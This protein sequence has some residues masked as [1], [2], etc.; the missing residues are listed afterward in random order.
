MG[1]ITLDGGLALDVVG[2]ARFSACGAGSVADKADSAV[3]AEPLVTGMS[4]ISVAFMADPGDVG[5]HWVERN[6]GAGFVLH[7]SKK[8]KGP[9]AFTYLVVEPGA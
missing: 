4:H 1:G 8:S 5:T 6:A 9:A 3:V 7:L 2:K